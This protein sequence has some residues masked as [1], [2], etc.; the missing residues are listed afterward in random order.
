MKSAVFVIFPLNLSICARMYF[1]SKFVLADLSFISKSI[2][3]NL[4]NF[5][6]AILLYNVSS[7]YTLEYNGLN[8]IINNK[9]KTYSS[10]FSIEEI[11]NIFISLKNVDVLSKST[12]LN[13]RDML[14]L[15]IVKICKGFY[16]K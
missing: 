8:K 7:D 16:A 12:S 6:K 5:F 11:I 4:S 13:H 1:F 9:L 15:L 14:F 3:K 10:N 2:T